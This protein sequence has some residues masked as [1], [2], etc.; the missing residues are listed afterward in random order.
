MACTWFGEICSCCCLTVWLGPAWVR[1]SK[2]YKP[3]AG[4]LYGTKLRLR[5]YEPFPR[6]F[7]A[8]ARRRERRSEKSRFIGTEAQ[9]IFFMQ[10]TDIWLCFSV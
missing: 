6:M 8:H 9:S 2:I 4:S 5:H 7:V 3:F 1:L 10:T